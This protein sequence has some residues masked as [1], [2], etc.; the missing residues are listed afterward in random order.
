MR[1]LSLTGIVAFVTGAFGLPAVLLAQSSLSPRRTFKA[2]ANA[3][4]LPDSFHT[5]GEKAG[6]FFPEAGIGIWPF[7]N[8]RFN[9]ESKVYSLRVFGRPAE[10]TNSDGSKKY[11]ERV[12]FELIVN[13]Y[14]VD[15]LG[16]S[17][18]ALKEYVLSKKG[19]PLSLSLPAWYWNT[20]RGD[21]RQFWMAGQPYFT[22]R[23]LPLTNANDDLRLNGTLGAGYTQQ[24]NIDFD[25]DKSPASLFLEVS[26]AANLLI[27]SDVTDVIYAT[28]SSTGKFIFGL[29]FRVGYRFGGEHSKYFSITGTQALKKLRDSKSLL[30]LVFG[31]T[32]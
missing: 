6:S 26:G 1:L 18:R 12:A 21:V 10:S 13:T 2:P 23:L 22:A 30:N 4:A 24:V 9:L 8:P 19:S 29:D 25:V 15:A 16:S 3:L 32:L 5:N 27:G 14:I 31:S 28:T 20:R 17:A 11:E 7:E